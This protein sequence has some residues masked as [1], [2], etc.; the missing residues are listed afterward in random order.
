MKKR[1]RIAAANGNSPRADVTMYLPHDPL[2]LCLGPCRDSHR[3]FPLLPSRTEGRAKQGE[4]NNKKSVQIKFVFRNLSPRALSAPDPSALP[5]PFSALF[6]NTV[7]RSYP[8]PPPPQI[9]LLNTPPPLPSYPVSSLP[10]HSFCN[11]CT[12]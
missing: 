8:P 9:S 7:P 3:S 6:P 11:L 12:L 2:R 1:T 4:K 10:K 5:H